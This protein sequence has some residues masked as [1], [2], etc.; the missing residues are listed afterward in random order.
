MI[1]DGRCERITCVISLLYCEKRF[2]D[3]E[4][5]LLFLEWKCAEDVCFRDEI[6]F[7]K[8]KLSL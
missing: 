4:L 5:A 1:S 3:V 8:S 2:C 7:A 6:L